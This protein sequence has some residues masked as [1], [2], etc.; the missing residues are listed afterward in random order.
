MFIHRDDADPE[1]KR[2]AEL[3]VAKHRNGPTGSIRLHFEP[4]LTQFRNAA[5]D[6]SV[7]EP[8]RSRRRAQRHAAPGPRDPRAAARSASA[9]WR[10]R[11]ASIRS[12]S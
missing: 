3:I 2:E 7:R 6:A 1:K 8:G 4:S 10:P 9:S 11:A 12:T 5:R